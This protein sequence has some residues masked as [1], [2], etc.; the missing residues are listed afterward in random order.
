M[1]KA[2]IRLSDL[3]APVSYTDGSIFFG[4]SFVTPFR[5][6]LLKTQIVRSPKFTAIAVSE[7]LLGEEE[8]ADIEDVSTPY[9][10]P[11]ELRQAMVR[12]PLDW[13]VLCLGHEAS[14]VELFCAYQSIAPVYLT[15]RERTLLVSWDIA[16]MIFAGGT[17]CNGTLLARS[18]MLQWTYACETILDRVYRLNSESRICVED[19]NFR[20]ELPPPKNFVRPHALTPG[21]N[22]ID[23]FFDATCAL[24]E[25]RPLRPDKTALELSGGMDSAITALAAAR[26]IGSP[27]LSY[28]AQFEG[29]IGIAQT[30]R[31]E[32]ISGIAG[33][34]DISIP[35]EY[36]ASY[37]PNSPRR[38]SL[39]VWPEDD[40]YP[41]LL[42]ALYRLIRAAGVD[43]IVSGLG[44]DELYPI[45]GHESASIAEGAQK[46]PFVTTRCSELAGIP[47]RTHPQSSL[48]ASCWQTAAGRSRSL[49]NAGLWPIY[50]FFSH[51]LTQFTFNLPLEWRRERALHR[52][53]L[54]RLLNDSVYETNY[55]KESFHSVV[56]TGMDRNREY[57]LE[58]IENAS[59]AKLGLIDKE[60]LAAAFN[61]GVPAADAVI[62]AAFFV[63]NFE[64]FFR[65]R[66]VYLAPLTECS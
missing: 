1:L 51:E 56:R 36:F 60:K 5:H 48:L 24:V 49:L 3:H 59:L 18:A 6:R 32:L 41:E 53:T 42:G 46:Y 40:S 39:G 13:L 30:V 34:R 9:D 54:S 16:D 35:A 22:P 8:A 33:T 55:L 25:M 14:S 64:C 10:N 44:G 26:T 27:I 28:G 2:H 23:S 15:I 57:V 61:Q 7:R 47:V 62:D 12:R 45:F 37:D 31:R 50:P 43:T 17:G 20:Y 65:D 21:A 58:L 52:R 4:E 63:L 38:Q 29:E 66:D 19:D 11:D